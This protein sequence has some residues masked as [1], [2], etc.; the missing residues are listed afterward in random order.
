MTE[1]GLIGKSLKHSFSKAYFEK[2][3]SELHLENYAYHNF[4]L[5]HIGELPGLIAKN[6]ALKG[7]NIT[8]PYKEQVVALLHDVSEEARE[9]GAVNCIKITR[10]RL[11]GYNTDAYGFAQSIKPFL[12]TNHQRALIL[13][14]GGAAKAVAYALK[15]VGVEVYFA[16]SS[17]KKT[18]QT[19]MYPEINENV[20]NAFKLIVNTTPLGLFPN[21]NECPPLPYHFFTKDHLAYDLIYNP[22]KTVFLKQAHANGAVI[23]NGL[24]MLKLQA[25]KSW[26]IW[27]Q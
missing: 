17:A 15:K 26:E 8:N 7:L 16:S 27:N 23:M 4:E 13:G 9:I 10:G 20:M 25:E 6:P 18:E 19:L 14:T 22:E 2:K 11:S 1:F 21:E 3:F 5:Q 24:S 12:D